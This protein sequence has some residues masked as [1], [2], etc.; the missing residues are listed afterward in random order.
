MKTWIES[1]KDY[2][3][4]SSVWAIPRTGTGPHAFVMRIMKGMT[5]VNDKV[6]LIEKKIKKNKKSMKIMI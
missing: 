5:N 1:L 4:G 2:N 3:T 6:Q